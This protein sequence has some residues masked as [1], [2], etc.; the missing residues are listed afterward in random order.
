MGFGTIRARVDEELLG[1]QYQFS[2]FRKVPSQATVA[3][4]WCDLSMAP[5]NPVPNYYASEPLVSAVLDGNKG[6][7]HGQSVAPQTKHLARLSAISTTANAVP[8]TLLLCDYLLYYPFVDMDSTDEQFLTNSVS[9]PRYT[10]GRGVQAILV[11]QGNY[12]GGAQFSIS[13]TNSEGVPGR[14]SGTVT[15]NTGTFTSS[16]ITSGAAAGNFGYAIPLASGDVGIRSVE[17]ITFSAP[18]GGIAALVLVKPL[19]NTML[20]EVTSPVERDFFIDF[21]SAP[22]IRDGA[23]LNFLAMPN[24]T[25]AAAPIIGQA[26]FIWG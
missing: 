11:A 4:T 15:S 13:Y 14:T 12:V 25:L 1:G 20:R 21:A 22:R 24:A 17:S 3:G 2:S 8:L 26:D 19:A 5:G 10:D 23:Y 9:L 18:N 6:I 16:L 7:Y